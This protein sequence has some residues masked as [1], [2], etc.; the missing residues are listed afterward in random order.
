MTSFARRLAQITRAP[1]TRS[2][3]LTPSSSFHQHAGFPHCAS[4]RAPP[5]AD[6]ARDLRRALLELLGADKSAMFDAAELRR[7]R[8]I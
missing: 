1:S 5:H 6:D 7:A 3:I 2:A 8:S 4:P